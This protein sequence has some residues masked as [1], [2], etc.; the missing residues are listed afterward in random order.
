MA[1]SGMLLLLLARFVS[2]APNIDVSQT[3]VYPEHGSISGVFHVWLPTG[4]AFDASVAREVCE[5]LGVTIADKSQVEKALEQGFETCKFGWIDE[6][7]AVIPRIHTKP[8]CGQGQVGIITWR[9]NLS[10]K[11]D[12]FC[13]NSTD[14]EAHPN[15][16]QGNPSTAVM[17][18]ARKSGAHPKLTTHSGFREDLQLTS[19]SFPESAD[20]LFVNDSP[21]NDSPESQAFSKTSPTITVSLI[22]LLTTVSAFLVLAVAAICYLKKNNVGWWNKNHQR[23]REETEIYEKT[24]RESQAEVKN[25]LNMTSETNDVSITI[26]LEDETREASHSAASD[27]PSL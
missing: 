20:E 22:A 18:T 13:F 1:K 21:V 27:S 5:G 11:F 14:Y 7:V 2:S 17:P 12:V 10:T 26:K 25:Q 16:P 9:A 15:P 19:S 23:Q 6:Q 24:G 8:S 3:Q 4:Y